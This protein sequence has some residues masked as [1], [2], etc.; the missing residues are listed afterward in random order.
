MADVANLHKN[1]ILY[2]TRHSRER[3]ID[4]VEFCTAS[5]GLLTDEERKQAGLQPGKVRLISD[6]GMFELDT[7]E[8]RFRLV[9]IHPGVTLDD[10]RAQTGGDFLVAEPLHR[11]AP[12][13]EDELRL[14]RE[15]VDPFGI[16]QLEF[17]PSR[18]RLALI[19][20]IL[21]AEAALMGDRQDAV[22]PRS[23]PAPATI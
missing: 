12:P 22:P 9:S 6:L 13:S 21:D 5:R 20:R 10:I 16:R 18:D 4:A 1:F 14:I 11:T 19:R 7:N 8:K 23:E 15:E 2:L 17:V 3:F